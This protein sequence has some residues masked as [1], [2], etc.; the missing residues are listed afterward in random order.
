MVVIRSGRLGVISVGEGYTEDLIQF[1]FARRV[2]PV[3]FEYQSFYV[4]EWMGLD[5]NGKI[6]NSG[7]HRRREF[8]HHTSVTVSL[9]DSRE[10]I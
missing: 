3:C 5:S 4:L 6:I 8:P 7:S 10:E 2:S 1:R 9:L